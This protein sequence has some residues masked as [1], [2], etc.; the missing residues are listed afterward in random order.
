MCACVCS[1]VY[2]YVYERERARHTHSWQVW[3]VNKEL[4]YPLCVYDLT[5]RYELDRVINTARS[6]FL[7][8]IK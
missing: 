6:D 7:D 5:Q 1:C 4:A 2:V 8:I 3:I